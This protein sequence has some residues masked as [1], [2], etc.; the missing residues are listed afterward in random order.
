MIMTSKK[1]VVVTPARNEEKFITKCMQSVADQT[2]PVTMHI[3]VDDWSDDGTKMIADSFDGKVVVIP[4]GLARGTKAHGIRP[5]LVTDVGIKKAT[6]LV[7]DWKYCLILDGDTWLPSNYCEA[8]ITEM[9]INPRLMMAGARFLRTPSGL[10]TAPE[11]HVRGSNHIIKRDLYEESDLG[12]SSAPGE[13]ILERIA[14]IMGFETR[15]LPLTAFE[16][17]A[18]G[19]TVDNP[20]LSGIYDYKLG[21]PILSLVVRLIHLRRADILELFGWIYGRLHGEKRY[22]T[23][24]R[25]RVL[26]R[27]YLDSL[28]KRVP[29]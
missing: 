28:I 8:I 27:R 18:T 6:E 7:P 15:S 12:Y 21:T 1:L 5:H 13:R 17:R 22:F 24:S 11:S 14:W 4:S 19:T 25:V 10:E 20:V 3:I 16:G 29:L 26:Y 2:Y 9:R 23:G